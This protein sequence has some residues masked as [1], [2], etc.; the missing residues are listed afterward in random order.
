[1]SQQLIHKALYFTADL[2][3]QIPDVDQIAA[4]LYSELNVQNQS[5]SEFTLSFLEHLGDTTILQKCFYPEIFLELKTLIDALEQNHKKVLICS[6]T[7]GNLFL[8][9]QKA[10]IFQE[11]LEPKYLAKPSIY[12]SL[13][14]LSILPAVFDD[15]TEADCDLICVIDDR[16]PNIESASKVKSKAESVFIHKIRPDKK[17]HCNLNSPQKNIY[18]ASQWPEIQKILLDLPA[19]QVGLVLDKD[20][21]IFN[22]TLYR[23]ILEESLTEWIKSLIA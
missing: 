20:G 1:M 12:A 18:Q 8:Q 4:F 16:L 13:D 19:K 11:C 5:L 3:S 14:K 21:I 10:Q 2:N 15:L 22:T 17:T 23:Q 7:Q 6:W 9:T